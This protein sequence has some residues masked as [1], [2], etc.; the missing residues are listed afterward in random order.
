MTSPLDH[1]NQDLRGQSFRGGDLNGADFAGADLRGVDFSNASL[2]EADFT[3]ARFGMGPLASA[4]LLAAAMAVSALAGLST[5]F[6][7]QSMR[8]RLQSG[9]DWQ[10]GF[11]G[12]LMLTV[13]A[14]FIAI[15][16]M[17]GAR[18]ALPSLVG[19]IAV[20]FIVDVTIVMF[21]GQLRLDRAP[22][23]IAL[24][25]LAGVAFVAGIL[26]RMVGG[27]F[28]PWAIGLMSIVGGLVAGIVEGGFAATLVAVL[29]VIMSKRTLKGDDRDRMLRDLTH[30]IV[31]RYGTRFTGADLSRATFAGNNLVAA[32]MTGTVDEDTVWG[33]GQVP[34]RLDPQTR[35]FG[36]RPA[37]A[38]DEPQG[39]R[40]ITE[41]LFAAA[42]SGDYSDAAELVSEDFVAYINGHKMG[43][44]HA[45]HSGPGLLT[46]I[47]RF[48]DGQAEDTFWH[49]YEEVD[50]GTGRHESGGDRRIAIRFVA[51]GTFDGDYKEIEVAG[52]LKITDKTMTELRFVTDLTTFNDMREAA[53]LETLA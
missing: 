8:E 3:E 2:V 28:G 9:T 15:L 20:A 45:P 40:P 6:F 42:N 31:S 51:S 1:S 26:G 7:M 39:D 52:F 14:T 47:L 27:A 29:L 32:D 10:D 48:F 5:A 25:L 24:L 4:I 30:R 41:F 50:G 34:Y 43:G 16:V 13:I 44:G 35:F 37:G 53:G 22:F 23:A 46:S 11:A 49:L 21:L 36:D 19:L 18:T 38:D 17:K 33:A 12:V